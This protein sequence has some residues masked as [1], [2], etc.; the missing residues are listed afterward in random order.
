MVCN[1]IQIIQEL[2]I[3][4]VITS[5]GL[6][7]QR[8]ICSKCYSA[9]VECNDK[10]IKYIVCKSRSLYIK[11]SVGQKQMK[12]NVININQKTFKLFVKTSQI[13]ALL[14]E[15]NHHERCQNDLIEDENFLFPLSSI[16]ILI[17][18]NPKTM[19]INTIALNNIGK[20]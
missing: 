6:I 19:N 9:N 8:Y 13:E 3:V 7:E 20:N 16:N 2:T 12:L 10:T 15:S 4:A 11:Y 17:N 18:F 1:S 5:I 14:E